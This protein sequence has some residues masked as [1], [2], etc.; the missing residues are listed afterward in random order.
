MTV[1]EIPRP[2]PVKVAPPT[3]KSRARPARLIWP[4]R[5]RP[6][7]EGDVFVVHLKIS[8]DGYVTGVRLVKGT[9]RHANAK[10]EEGAWRFRYDPARDDAGE[11]IASELEQK[12]MIE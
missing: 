4:V 10:A 1:A 8:A 5:D 11:P 7:T 3:P 2:P 12:L 9:T 6:E